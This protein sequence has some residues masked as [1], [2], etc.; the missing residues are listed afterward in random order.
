M[1]AVFG[2][3]IRSYLRVWKSAEAAGRTLNEEAEIA[4][5]V[6][7]RRRSATAGVAYLTTALLCLGILT[8][9]L[10]LPAADL[11]IPLYG[12][13]DAFFYTAIVKDLVEHGS[14]NTNPLLGAPGHQEL[15]DFPLPHAV[16]F[17][18][19]RLLS[20]FTSNYALVENLYYLLT[21]PLTA[22]ASLFVFRTF[23]ISY[24]AAIV[25]SVLFAFLPYH[26]LR[27]E[28]HLTYSSYYL[29]PLVVLVLL[30]I[31]TGE[32]LFGFQQFQRRPKVTARGI[33]SIV[34]CILIA[35]DTPYSAFFAAFFL[36][37]AGILSRI[38]Y[39]HRRGMYAAGILLATLVLSFGLNLA[40][41][42]IYFQRHGLNPHVARRLPEE[43]EIYGMKI[44]PLVLPVSGHRLHFFDHL[45]NRYNQ[46]VVPGWVNTESDVASLGLIGSCGFLFLI[47]FLFLGDTGRQLLSVLSSLNIAAVLFGTIG[48]FGALFALLVS[49]EIRGYARI[50]VFIAF[51]S[52]LGIGHLLDRYF[53]TQR[54]SRVY[55]VAACLLFLGIFDQ[56]DKYMV[57]HHKELKAEYSSDDSFV[58][59]IE[60]ALPQNAMIFQLPYVAFP[61]SSP[62]N[63]ML[64]YDLMRGFLHSNTL[65][66][67]Y[68][69]MK[70]REDDHWQQGVAAQPVDQMV[71]TL[72][73]AG[74]SGIYIDRFGYADQAAK[75][76]SE[77]SD[78]L[79]ELPTVSPNQRLSFFSLEKLGIGLRQ[80]YSSSDWSSKQDAALHPPVLLSDWKGGFSSFEG[81]AEQNWRWCSSNE[82]ELDIV[83]PSEFSRKVELEMGVA[84]A[85]AKTAHFRIESPLFSKDFALSS[86]EQHIS[87]TLLLPP[88]KYP[89]RMATD[90]PTLHVPADPR[91]F[92]FRVNNFRLQY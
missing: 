25:G 2:N 47:G 26:L 44:A 83:N 51:F 91:T 1:K 14:S 65:H 78:A 8:V 42:L 75:L 68:G 67:S 3:S 17:S 35:A 9:V 92:V 21:F 22:L 4:K 32:L 41:N 10:K 60:S 49:P 46:R 48:G 74:F 43:A 55:F 58:K 52:F 76:E 56:T 69:A 89:I 31:C 77:L 53:A 45:K 64:D 7:F 63:R 72:V 13:Y 82:G 57:P 54:R 37:F 84:T 73:L 19:I 36:A 86:K 50:C 29:V 30:W 81:T 28:A 59:T 80:R 71:Q 24:P 23:K 88:G 20:L 5:A 6:G 62:V 12:N 85:S 40:P 16:H 18:V 70:G 66:W 38:R 39:G 27:A 15:Y 11:S 34:I 33:F 87:A 61:E 79:Q 90:A